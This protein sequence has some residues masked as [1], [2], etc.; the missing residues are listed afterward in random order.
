MFDTGAIIQHDWSHVV[1]LANYTVF[2]E[3]LSGMGKGDLWEWLLIKHKANGFQ[4]ETKIILGYQ[5]PL[6]LKL[7]GIIT[8]LSGHFNRSDYGAFDENFDGSFMTIKFSPFVQI[9]FSKKT[10]LS[11]LIDISSTRSFE[12]EYDEQD[13]VPFL[14]TSGREWF[15]NRIAFSIKHYF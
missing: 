5:M 12:Q 10:M 13:E 2:Y 8:E 6:K 3:G 15:C 14:T 1:M 7:T 11:A 4:Y 9:E